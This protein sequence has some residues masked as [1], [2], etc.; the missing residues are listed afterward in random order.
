MVQKILVTSLAVFCSPLAYAQ[1][2]AVSTPSVDTVAAMPAAPAVKPAPVPAFTT[3]ADLYYRYDLGKTAANNRTSFT[4]SHNSFELGMITV[5]AEHHAGKIGLVADIGF[6]KRAEEFSYADDRTRFIIKQLN[7]S[8]E[9]RYGIQLTAGSWATHVGYEG[10]DAYANRNYSMS[11]MFSYGPF[12]HTGLKVAKAF[13]KTGLMFGIANPTDLKSTTFNHK[14]VIGQLS[15]AT[16]NDVL[17]AWLNYQGG[18]PNDSTRINQFDLVASATLSPKWSLGFNGTLS[19]VEHKE[20]AEGFGAGRRWWGT[21]LYVNTDPLDWLGLTL[22]AE[23]FDDANQIN[24]FSAMPEGGNVFATTVSFNLKV[25]GL[26]LIPEVRFE[27]A[28]AALFAGEGG[29]PGSSS[30][31]FLVAAVYK[32]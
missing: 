4:N 3:A 5:K 31:G 18:Q 24:V 30:T 9:F 7:L 12:F 15:T 16:K 19:N 27:K 29:A 21:A 2:A 26:T 10:V 17:K 28:S 8:Y 25:Q 22:R 13:G 14:Y 6:G 20:G 32:L 23:Y 11:Y 1:L